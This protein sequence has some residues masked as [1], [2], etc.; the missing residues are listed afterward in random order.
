M[1][2]KLSRFHYALVALALLAFAPSDA[3][4]Q[5]LMDGG[6]ANAIGAEMEAGAAG[7]AANAA[8][9]N[10][11]QQP[12]QP[13]AGEGGGAEAA[14]AGEQAAQPAKNAN[15]PQMTDSNGLVRSRRP[16]EQDKWGDEHAM[17]R[18]PRAFVSWWKLL[19]VLFTFI[20][21]VRTCDWVNRASQIHN[22]GYARWN[23]IV[24]FTGFA[25]L[26][27]V[28]A[29]PLFMATMPLYAL[30]V[31]GPFIAFTIA[32][33]RAVGEH[34]RVFT[35]DWWRYTLAGIANKFGGKFDVEKRADYEK[36]A[37]VDLFALG[38][39]D[40]RA[41]QA[42]LMT[43]RQSPGYV[44]VK[45]LIADMSDR[46]SDRV[47]FDYGSDSVAVR[48]YIDGVWSQGEP[49]DRESGDVMLAV[50]KQLA[51]LNV[52]ERAKKQ[53]GKFAAKYNGAS[54]MCPIVSQGVKTGERVMLTL[55][56]AAVQQMKTYADLGMRSKLA[57]QWA[58]ALVL[59]EGLLLIAAM[60]EGG[61]TTLTDVSLMETDRLMRDVIS[62]EPKQ[63][64][65]HEI[66]NV[67]QFFYDPS[68][69]ETPG[70]HLQKLIRKYPDVYIVRDFVDAETAKGYIDQALDDNLV[71][72]TTRAKEVSE[73][74][75]RV[76]QKKAPRKEFA[77]ALKAVLNTR[78]IRLLC[79]TCKVGYEATPE[80]LKKLGIPPGKVQTLYR[81]PNAE[82]ASKPCKK[83][84][85]VGYFGR[86]GLFELLMVD[87]QVREAIVKE[88]KVEVIRKAAR[89]A[90]MRTLQEEGVLLIAK[91]TTSL[92]ELQ[93]I[94]K[95]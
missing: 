23:A 82:E 44:L 29:I 45:D 79:P 72:T 58:E 64:H 61:L 28:L 67:E 86:T 66:E 38:A 92:Q 7:R 50:M 30:L 51:N 71:I 65:E 9:A 85:G 17:Y 52:K 56:G 57:E 76:L 70:T 62:V 1:K 40:E 54:Y 69:G 14:P 42:N 90:G 46:R 83:C 87:D 60:P 35:A 63:A 8:P 43:S 3:W 32:H 75:L 5:A 48:H 84:G 2:L 11:Q 80:F 16:G 24:A 13:A 21:W 15:A 78:L 36:G 59:P 4:A 25:G 27:L 47:M 6:A 74:I 91:G 20:F 26:L 81:P 94:L 22:L 93:R 73:A 34:Q 68:I 31:L 12:Q 55:R 39:P 18:D 41:D 89:A 49:R 19:L 77:R 53:S 10:N 33:N 95:Q 37:Q 88:P